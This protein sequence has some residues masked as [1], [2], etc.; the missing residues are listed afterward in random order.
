MATAVA[1]SPARRRSLQAPQ[2]R[3]A[4][5]FVLPFFV[6]F[7]LITVTPL[8]YAVWVSMFQT[9]L[10]GGTKFVG[11]ENFARVFTDPLFYGSLGRVLAYMAIQIPLTLGLAL[12]FALM[13][14]TRRVR[15]SK[16]ARLLMFVPNAIPA[17]VATLMWGYIYGRDF[18]PIA[19]FFQFLGL[20]DPNLLGPS[21]ILGSIV[22]IS[23]WSGL[24]YSMIL[25]YAALQSIPSELYEAATLDGAGQFRIAWSVKIPSIAPTITLCV[26][27]SFIGG[28]QLFNEPNLLMMIAPGS[29]TTNYTPN[30]YIY[31]T[32]F[33]RQDLGYAAAMSFVLGLII[34]VASYVLQRATNRKERA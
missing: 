28:F 15:G 14:D 27:L 7:L 1:A 22:N 32:A 13:F 29:I 33:G 18:G 34:V 8:L 12:L 2:R 5:V 3:I 4:Y 21:E 9:Q 6:I 20:P 30:L 19:Q 10:I 31:N 24:G 16:A 26:I 17:V 11:L 25:F 23:F